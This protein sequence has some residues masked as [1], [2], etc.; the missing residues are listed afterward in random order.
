MYFDQRNRKDGRGV[1][2]GI[3]WLISILRQY[4]EQVND[5]WNC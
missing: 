5:S 2:E 3:Y 1:G 4:C